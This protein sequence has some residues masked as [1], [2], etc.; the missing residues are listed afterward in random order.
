MTVLYIIRHCESEGNVSEIFQGRTDGD[1]TP[2]GALQLESLKERCKDI[3]FDIIYTSPLIR[4]RKTA[5]AVNYYHD[6]ALI[7]E[8]ELMEINGGDM[9]GKKWED[10]PLLFPDTYPTWIKDFGS[11]KAPGGESV[12]EVYERIKRAVIRIVSE[13]NGKT[14]GIV[15]HGGAIYT[16]LAFAYGVSPDELTQNPFWCENTAISRVNFINGKPAPIFMNDTNHINDDDLTAPRLM[17]W[18]ETE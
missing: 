2:K 3:P 12:R 6:A 7:D 16:L 11:F 8:P 13:N 17:L 18:R 4:A 5:E 1:I 9:E 15:S 10:L 14:V